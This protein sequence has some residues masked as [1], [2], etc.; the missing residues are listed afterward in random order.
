MNVIWRREWLY[1]YESPWSVF[2]KLTLVNLADRN[3]LL[4]YFGNEN[5]KV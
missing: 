3:D 1:E 2:E 5:I 4:R